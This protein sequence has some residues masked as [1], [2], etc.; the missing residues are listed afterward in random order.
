MRIFY[1]AKQLQQSAE[2][3]L[4]QWAFIPTM[5][6]LHQGHISLIQKA[7]EQGHKTLVSI[8]VNPTQFNNSEDLKRYPRTVYEDL[9]KLSQAQVDAVFLPTVTEVYPA[10]NE[11]QPVN[12]GSEAQ[13]LEG[14][15]R[16]GHFEGVVMVLRRLFSMVKP[17]CVFF[18]QKDLQQ[19]MVV[20]RLIKEEFPHIQFNMIDTMR[21]ADGLAMS[22]RNALL[23]S[24]EREVASKIY[25]TLRMLASSDLSKNDI[26][27]KIQELAKTG[28]QTEYLYYV[29]IP[30]LEVVSTRHEA[31]A[32]V[33]AG[34][35][36]KVRLIDNLVFN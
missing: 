4:N 2:L 19:C 1:T 3:H 8:F 27:I 20:K 33:Y 12:L 14:Y 31:G 7:R 5:G 26:E 17:G 6:A 18:G 32:V 30:E 22:S 13:G 11:V 36:G 28:I 29:T 9:M 34:Y 15:F 21:E 25:E 23:S 10:Q 24:N 35:L 16:P